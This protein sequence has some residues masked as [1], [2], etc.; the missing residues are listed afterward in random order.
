MQRC[1]QP[2]PCSSFNLDGSIF[3]YAVRRVAVVSRLTNLKYFILKYLGLKMLLFNICQVS[4]DWSK[5]A[6]NHNP[7][8]AKNYI[9]LHPTQVCWPH[10]KES[11]ST[12]LKFIWFL[13]RSS[14]CLLVSC[15]NHFY[16]WRFFFC[17]LFIPIL[18]T[19][20]PISFFR[21]SNLWWIYSIHL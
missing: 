9:L 11:I 15:F 14:G 13:L 19:F 20:C 18:C 8:T 16:S 21:E 12:L 4:Y 7:A 6:E 2:I 10:V 17:I 3:A 1:N 5:G